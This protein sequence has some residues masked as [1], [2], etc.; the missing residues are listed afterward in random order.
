VILAAIPVI[1]IM[2]DPMPVMPPKV[3]NQD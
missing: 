1:G 3:I 2:A